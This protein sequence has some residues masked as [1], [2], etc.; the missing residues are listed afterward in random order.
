MDYLSTWTS[1]IYGNPRNSR[2]RINQINV[3]WH[4]TYE[5]LGNLFIK[6]VLVNR[7]LDLELERSAD[8]TQD[9]G[10]VLSERKRECS[11]KVRRQKLQGCLLSN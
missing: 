3:N 10:H 4:T 1:V 8:G 9:V 7:F 2:A 11:T 6:V 5:V